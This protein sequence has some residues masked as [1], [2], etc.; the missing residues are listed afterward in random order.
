MEVP[1]SRR[2]QPIQ[3]G[4]VQTMPRTPPSF[5]FHCSGQP[6]Q[7]VRFLETVFTLSTSLDA[8]MSG[9]ID[10][11]TEEHGA[12]K[13]GGKPTSLRTYIQIVRQHRRI[14]CK[15]FGRRRRGRSVMIHSKWPLSSFFFLL[16]SIQHLGPEQTQIP[17]PSHPPLL[18][19]GD[20]STHD[21][22]VGLMLLLVLCRLLGYSFVSLV[23]AAAG[24]IITLA[25][26]LQGTHSEVTCLSRIWMLLYPVVAVG[27]DV[28]AGG[29]KAGTKFCEGMEGYL[30][31]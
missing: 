30:S 20:V 11:A 23:V 15:K 26:I 2:P 19:D 13:A 21:R 7:P 6:P 29:E 17:I 12:C 22:E 18:V 31:S 27:R 16:G 8:S 24:V 25:V 9:E 28:G 4:A 10:A 3:K 14:I 5:L 1:P